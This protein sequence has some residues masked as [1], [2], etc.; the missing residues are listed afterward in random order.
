MRGRLA[1]GPG[2][3]FLLLTEIARVEDQDA[4]TEPLKISVLSQFKCDPNGRLYNSLQPAVNETQTCS[5][6]VQHHS[7]PSVK[8]DTHC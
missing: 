8:M 6:I 7:V 5:N 1:L 4:G 2:Q 3:A